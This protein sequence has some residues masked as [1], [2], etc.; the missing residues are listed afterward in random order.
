MSHEGFLFDGALELNQSR[1]KAGLFIYHSGTLRHDIELMPGVR[2]KKGDNYLSLHTAGD[3]KKMR[4][5]LGLGGIF[6]A[7]DTSLGI[8]AS[9]IQQAELAHMFG[10]THGAYA[11]IASR[12]YGFE[13][14]DFTPTDAQI[15]GLSR[16]FNKTRSVDRDRKV[17]EVKVVYM[18]GNNFLGKFLHS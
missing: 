11:Q 7:M 1:K 4:Q 18:T 9:Q 13:L 15:Q 17:T 12:R 5:L 10:V 3:P 16:L 2:M 14:G 6:A 8:L